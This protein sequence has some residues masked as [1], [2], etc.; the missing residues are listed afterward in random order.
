MIVLA[1]DARVS[2]VRSVVYLLQRHTD[3]SAYVVNL[4]GKWFW[5]RFRDGDGLPIAV[6]IDPRAL[7]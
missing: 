5:L 1:S 2:V 4:H 3:G 7:R 6:K